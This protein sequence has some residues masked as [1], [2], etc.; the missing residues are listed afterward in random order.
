MRVALDTNVMACAEGVNG[1]EM[2]D[3]ALSLIACLPADAVVLLEC[4]L[5]IVIAGLRSLPGRIVDG[6]HSLPA[7]HLG[8]GSRTSMKQ[9][10]AYI[11][12]SRRAGVRRRSRRNGF[13]RFAHGRLGFG[14]R[15]GLFGGRRFGRRRFLNSVAPG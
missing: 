4:L 15:L 9:P 12:K 10:R 7:R 1:E 13:G 8:G 5:V 2:R 14:L 3:R 6:N 11:V